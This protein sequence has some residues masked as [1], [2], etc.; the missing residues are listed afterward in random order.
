MPSG[1]GRYYVDESCIYCELCVD[2]APENFAYD[3]E[4]GVAYVKKQPNSNTEHN[5][6]AEIIDSCPVDS[7]GDKMI[8]HKDLIDDIGLGTGTTPKSLSGGI[9]KIIARWFRKR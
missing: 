9:T 4:S 7:I 5:L 6:L 2:T 3:D 1:E 8:R